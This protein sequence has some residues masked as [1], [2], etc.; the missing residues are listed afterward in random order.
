MPRVVPPVTSR[1]KSHI[2]ESGHELTQK[3][4]QQGRRICFHETLIPL[5]PSLVLPSTKLPFFCSTSGG[6]PC[7][8]GKYSTKKLFSKWIHL[9]PAGL[10]GMR[11]FRKC[12]RSFL[13]SQT[14]H[15][16]EMVSCRQF[17]T[18]L[19]VCDPPKCLS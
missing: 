18:F 1:G 17:V 13:S 11:R 19:N 8:G 15:R 2:Y 16:L 5:L 9:Q 3:T 14:C 6:G 4:Y 10:C 12:R 7:C